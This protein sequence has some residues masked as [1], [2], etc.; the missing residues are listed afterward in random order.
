V[1]TPGVFTFFSQPCPRYCHGDLF[2]GYFEFFKRA[3]ST[4][5]ALICRFP[6][7]REWKSISLRLLALILCSNC[8]ISFNNDMSTTC[9]LLLNYY[10]IIG[11]IT[12][13]CI[14]S[15]HAWSRHFT[16]RPDRAPHPPNLHPQPNI[17]SRTYDVAKLVFRTPFPTLLF[18]SG[19]E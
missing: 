7:I 19:S 6:T 12:G 16:N 4:F 5:C 13:A 11:M 1:F 15:F 10:L 14:K 2:V 9:R 8:S 18:L 17:T 3:E